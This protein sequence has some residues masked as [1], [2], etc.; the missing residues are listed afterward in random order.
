VTLRAGF[1]VF[2]GHTILFLILG[3][4]VFV[5]F[6]KD[7]FFSLFPKLAFWHAACPGKSDLIANLSPGAGPYSLVVCFFKGFSLFPRVCDLFLCFPRF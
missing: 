2:A 6:G 7:I 1:P 4:T 5:C 3:D